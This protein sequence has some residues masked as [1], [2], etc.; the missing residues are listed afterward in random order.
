[1]AEFLLGDDNAGDG[2]TKDGCG[3]EGGRGDAEGDAND[4]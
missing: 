4:C 3:S 2:I 1:M